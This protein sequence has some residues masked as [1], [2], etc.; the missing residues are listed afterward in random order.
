MSRVEGG[1]W[2]DRCGVEI[3]WSPLVKL[4]PGSLGKN[5]YC[6][7][8]CYAGLPCGCGERMEME[9]ERRDTP[10]MGIGPQ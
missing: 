8:D 7:N 6:C 3:T 9:E 5:E 10:G 1:I 2:C 4:R